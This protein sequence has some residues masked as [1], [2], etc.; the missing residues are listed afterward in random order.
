MGDFVTDGVELERKD[1]T[2]IRE[3]KDSLV[4]VG[5]RFRKEDL[6]FDG[7]EHVGEPRDLNP[8]F[9]QTDAESAS[10][11]LA[12]PSSEIAGIAFPASANR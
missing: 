5:F 3:T 9:V 4:Q 7:L 6:V 8:I 2:I 10:V 12:C 11:G 1:R